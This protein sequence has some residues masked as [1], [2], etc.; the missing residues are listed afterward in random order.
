VYIISNKVTAVVTGFYADG[1]TTK[2][3]WAFPTMASDFSLLCFW[4]PFNLLFQWCRGIFLTGAEVGARN[5]LVFDV[6]EAK[7]QRRAFTV[8]TKVKFE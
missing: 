1:Y 6:C 7:P 2:K 4:V 8:C 3:Y 5:T